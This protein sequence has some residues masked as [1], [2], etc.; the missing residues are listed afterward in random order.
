MLLTHIRP[1][2][3][4]A[5]APSMCTQKAPRALE[6]TENFFE[7]SQIFKC[8]LCLLGAHTGHAPNVKRRSKY[9]LKTYFS[10]MLQ[11]LILM[12]IHIGLEDWILGEMGIFENFGCK[13]SINFLTP[14]HYVEELFEFLE[15]EAVTEISCWARSSAFGAKG[16]HTVCAHIRHKPS[17]S[18][19]EKLPILDEFSSARRFL[20][21]H[22]L[23]VG[24]GS[25][26]TPGWYLYHILIL[27]SNS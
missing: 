12:E 14:P 25:S 20:R 21:V 15:L 26:N 2:W 3:G 5:R 8:W 10:P 22:I 24:W 1:L 18:V 19:S 6:K 27:A 23:R 11:L 4:E 13:K 9:E 16:A 7:N 17:Y